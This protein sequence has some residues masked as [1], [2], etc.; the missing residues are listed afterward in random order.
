MCE[1]TTMSID[2]GSTPAAAS[3]CGS[4]PTVGAIGP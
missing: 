3:D 4:R 2:L 1:I